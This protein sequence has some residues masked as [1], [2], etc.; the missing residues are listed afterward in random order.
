MNI[1]RYILFLSLLFF[2]SNCGPTKTVI[3]TKVEAKIDLSG[4]W[5]DTDSRLTSEKLAISLLNSSWLYNYLI[6]HNKKPIII[7]GK[8]RNKTS[9]HIETNLFGRDIERELIKSG[10]VKFVASNAE[11]VDIRIERLD[12]QQYSSIESSKRLAEETG[13]DFILA[14]TIFSQIDSIEGQSVKYYQV[15]LAL[16]NLETNEKVWMDSKKIKKIVE[17]SKYKW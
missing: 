13:A 17:Q 1:D 15:D 4:K 8:I 10:K 5:N 14:G 11:R 9:E 2:F 7:T 16:I 12:Q 6:E 3:R